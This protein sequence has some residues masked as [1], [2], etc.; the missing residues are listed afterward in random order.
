MNDQAHDLRDR[1]VVL[2]YVSGGKEFG[3]RAVCPVQAS[4][5]AR[6]E[7][8]GVEDLLDFR[9]AY[10]KIIA[11]DGFRSTRQFP[12]AEVVEEVCV[13]R[14]RRDRVAIAEHAQGGDALGDG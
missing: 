7:K 11:V 14:L 12:D 4:L 5:A 2:G 10:G 8:P 13:T 9:F 3:I 6:G 1:Q